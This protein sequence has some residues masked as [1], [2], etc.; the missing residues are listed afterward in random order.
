M[1]LS[2]VQPLLQ[3]ISDRGGCCVVLSG[4]CIIQFLLQL[5]KAVAFEAALSQRLKPGNP[6][7]AAEPWLSET[8][9]I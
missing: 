2:P 8:G 9:R 4:N 1:R 3:V 7:S 6:I 5:G